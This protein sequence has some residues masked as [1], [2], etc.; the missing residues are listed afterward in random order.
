MKLIL[1]SAMT[2]NRVIGKNRA[3]PWKIP[4]EYEHFL[5]TVRGYPIIIGR[6]SYEIFGADLPESRMIVVSSSLQE[7]PGADVC[8]GIEQAVERAAR[9]GERAFSA[10]GASI[11]RQTMPQAQAMHLSF[12]KDDFDGD[13]Y[14]PAWD[15]AAWEVRRTEDRGSYEFRVYERREEPGAVPTK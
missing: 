9:Y 5:D 14:F 11:Y 15:D 2:R 8:P 4:E 13:T 1:I 10:G 3:L 7:L 12:I 6:T